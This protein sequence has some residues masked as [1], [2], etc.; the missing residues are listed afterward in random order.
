MKKLSSILLSAVLLMGLA[1]CS[2][3]AAGAYKA[4]TYTGTGTGRNG[5][6]TVEVTFSDTAITKIEVTD[7]QETAGIA[8]AALTELPQTIVDTQ[9][10]GV[11]AV[12]GATYTSNGILEAVADAVT[13]AGGDVVLTMG[14]GSIS[15]VPKQL[16]ALV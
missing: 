4:G 5:D 3:T 9:S 10:L 12:A 7:Q 6:I 2:S 14:A 13:K 8:D 15:A 16:L 11:A 1:G